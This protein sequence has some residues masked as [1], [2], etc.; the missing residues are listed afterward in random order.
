MKVR[1]QF[2]HRFRMLKALRVSLLLGAAYDLFF[3]ACMVW[4]PGVPAAWLD[5]PLPGESFYLWLTAVL[6]TM[7]ALLYVQAA[8]DPRRYSAVI[9]VAVFGR[10]LGAAVFLI[11]ALRGTRLEG[12]YPLAAADALFGAAHAVFWWRIR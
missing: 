4:A 2:L 3:A 12:L 6:L 10:L 5:L 7:L 1:R 9:V 11:A 8:R